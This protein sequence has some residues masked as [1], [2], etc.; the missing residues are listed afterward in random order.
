MIRINDYRQFIAELVHV[1]SEESGV[2][3]QKIRLGTT[4]EQL[5]NLLKDQAGVVVA[6]N[7]PGAAENRNTGFCV[8]R[9]ECLLMVLEKTPEDR[10]GTEWEYTEYQRL[11]DLMMAI[12][13]LLL[14]AD[15]FDRFCDKG[16]I[17]YSRPINVEWEYNAYGG[18]NGLSAT[19]TLKDGNV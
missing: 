10:Q 1:A 19:F 14:N 11:Q 12:V 7:I 13:R 3:A 9:G 6:G 2:A 17:D 16:E 4:E 15:G 18:F 5:I 8:G